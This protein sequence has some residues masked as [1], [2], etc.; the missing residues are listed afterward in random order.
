MELMHEIDQAYIE[1]IE[2][3]LDIIEGLLNAV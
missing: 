2:E 3:E 1:V